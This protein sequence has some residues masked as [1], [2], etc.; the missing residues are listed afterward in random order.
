MPFIA[1]S[2]STDN[3]TSYPASSV[4]TNQ[5]VFFVITNIEHEVI[6]RNGLSSPQDMYV[7][8]TIGEL[9][10]WIDSTVTLMVQTGIE[11]SCVP[12]VAG[13]IGAGLFISA[14]G[15]SISLI[16]L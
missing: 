15:W 6:Q 8:S 4:R 16:H 2:S 14:I 12:D 3:I 11:H 10:C 9:G 7:G 5:V 1:A 13:Y